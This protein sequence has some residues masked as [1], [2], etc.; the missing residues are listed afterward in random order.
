[1]WNTDTLVS[2]NNTTRDPAAKVYSH[3]L[4]PYSSCTCAR[5]A[6]E[7]ITNIPASTAKAVAER[8]IMRIV[9]E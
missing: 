5:W 4:Y 2:Y 6:G 9:Y 1:M 8:C 7:N 3:F